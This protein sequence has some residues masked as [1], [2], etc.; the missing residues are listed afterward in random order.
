[1]ITYALVFFTL[2]Q[3]QHISIDNGASTDTLCSD[4]P[5]TYRPGMHDSE[6]I[7]LIHSVMLR[8]VSE[9][10]RDTFSSPGPLS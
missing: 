8:T 10:P 9:M 2:S 3:Q 4:S 1:M 6:P 5:L 7:G